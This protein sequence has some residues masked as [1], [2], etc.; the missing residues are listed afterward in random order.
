MKRQTLRA[1]SLRAEIGLED[2][3]L[4][5]VTLPDKIP[6]E[7]DAAALA[8]LC[9]QLAAYPIDLADAPPFIGAVWKRMMQIPAGSALTYSEL[10]AAVGRPLAFRAVGQACATNRRL[11]AIPCHRV[12]AADGL[13]GFGPGLHWKR[14]LLELEA[15]C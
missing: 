6:D 8:D 5:S 2:G 12:V 13:G 7:F 1:G 15:H 11:L 9:A 10:A 4:R 3:R 14:K